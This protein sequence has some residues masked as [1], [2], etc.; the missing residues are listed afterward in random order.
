MKDSVACFQFSSGSLH[1]AASIEVSESASGDLE[2]LDYFWWGSRTRYPSIMARQLDTF[3]SDASPKIIKVLLG[4]SRFKKINLNPRVKLPKHYFEPARDVL[5]LQLSNCQDL[6]SL[7]MLDFEGI[8]PGPAISNAL[9]FETQGKIDKIDAHRATL[10][11]LLISYLEIYFLAS[12]HIKKEDYKSVIVYNGRFLH[13]RAVWDACKNLG[14]DVILYE[15]VRDR[16]HYRHNQGFHNHFVNQQVMIDH[17]NNSEFS[18][19]KKVEIGSRYF[20]DLSSVKNAFYN[21]P[22]GPVVSKRKNIVFFSNSDDEYVGFREN[23]I[24]P[25]QLETIFQIAKYLNC[26]NDYDFVVRLHPNLKNKSLSEQERWGALSGIPTIRIFDQFSLQDSY[27][28]M[29][30]ASG[31]IS[32]GSTIGLEASFWEIPSLVFGECSYGRL[33][34]VD[35]VTNMGEFFSWI[36]TLP[37]VKQQLGVRKQNACIRGF[38]L[39]TGGSK[40]EN[41]KLLESGWG[42]WEV[43]EFRGVSLKPRRLSR[44][45]HLVQNL[46]KRK[47][48]GFHRK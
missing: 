1:L 10:K 21:P 5:L 30:N 36:D 9:A 15:T 34:A 35:T 17:W 39:E 7:Y 20:E 19:E 31:V 27:E 3:L 16:F 13:E 37:L 43:N 14:Q 46:I 12:E 2:N 29:R 28:L 40:I 8:T 38:W 26:S 32:F 41:S 33:G 42:A 23:G 24:L 6:D 11:K 48:R 4:A 47:W 44:D 22:S 25:D 18:L 45:I